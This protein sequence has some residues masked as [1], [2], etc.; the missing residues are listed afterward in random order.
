MSHLPV[1][2]IL[3]RHKFCDMARLEI[4]ELVML[5]L[6]PSVIF[7]PGVSVKTTSILTQGMCSSYSLETLSYMQNTAGM[8][9]MLWFRPRHEHN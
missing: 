2:V 6:L 4:Y 1:I 3:K 9:G 8:Y 7:K 5:S